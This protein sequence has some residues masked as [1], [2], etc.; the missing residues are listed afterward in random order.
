LK[1]ENPLL[2]LIFVTPELGFLQKRE[3]T[4][5]ILRQEIPVF[6]IYWC[7]QDD[8]LLIGTISYQVMQDWDPKEHLLFL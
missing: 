2:E 7:P 5:M 6:C 4:L 1:I 3:G 8:L